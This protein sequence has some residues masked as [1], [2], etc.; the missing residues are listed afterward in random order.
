MKTSL[1]PE[2]QPFSIPIPNTV[3]EL[4]GISLENDKNKPI[5][6]SSYTTTQNFKKQPV[7]NIN[8]NHKHESKHESKHN[9]WCNKTNQ[10]KN[11]KY[12]ARQI[13]THQ[14]DQK[15]SGLVHQ[16]SSFSHT[17]PPHLHHQ[18]FKRH[19]TNWSQAHD[20]S[21]NNKQTKDTANHK[22]RS[23]SKPSSHPYQYQQY[24][25]MT[26]VII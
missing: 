18:P 9:P 2:C 11:T 4:T 20:V 25:A 14:S 5:H 1:V 3:K 10:K 23:K 7:R 24:S 21:N 13:L 22:D 19:Q 26:N 16:P 15:P 6:E 17:Q 8:A 12:K